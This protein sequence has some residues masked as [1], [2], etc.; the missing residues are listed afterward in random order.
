MRR[1]L[2][3]VGSAAA[4]FCV[5]LYIS[6]GWSRLGCRTDHIDINSGEIRRRTYLLWAVV[7]ERI[8]PTW[9]SQSLPSEAQRDERDW[10]AVNTFALFGNHSPHHV[11]HSA[12]AHMNRLGPDVESG[13]I[14]PE[15]AALLACNVVRLWRLHSDDYV[16]GKYMLEVQDTAYDLDSL[17]AQDVPDVEQWLQDQG[18]TAP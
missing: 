9:V 10:R 11:F 12:I 5:A 18:L 2:I 14:T 3:I 8:D 16:A 15:A 7:F 4:L 17:R 1:K 13:K 6:S